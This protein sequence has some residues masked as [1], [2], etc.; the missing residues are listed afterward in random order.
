M[1]QSYA[2]RT[3][4]WRYI[5]YENGKE[6][7]YRVVDDP[8][9][10]SNLAANPEHAAQLEAFRTQLRAM[11]PKPDPTAK[12]AAEMSAAEWKDTFYK[13]HPA[14]DANS[15][16]TLSWPE[17]QDYKKRLDAGEVMKPKANPKAPAA[18]G[19]LQTTGTFSKTADG[20]LI[21]TDQAGG[22]VYYAIKELAAAVEPHLGKPV[23][24]IANVKDSTKG[25]AKVMVH[26]VSVR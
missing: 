26:L 8:R 19:R 11:M 7:L 23:K 25:K 12:P 10:W 14:A 18:A 16:G 21:F 5:R 6:E 1:Q 9:E 15:D 2:L 4:E 3:A 24:I 20:G 13:S 17:Y 22:Q